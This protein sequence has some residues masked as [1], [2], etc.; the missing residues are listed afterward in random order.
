MCIMTGRPWKEV[1][2]TMTMP[3]LMAMEKVWKT[4]P[5]PA[6]SLSMIA[7]ANGMKVSKKSKDKAMKNKNVGSALEL[8]KALKV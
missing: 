5:S 2:E 7:Q 4:I 1:D 3:R 6:I 8:A